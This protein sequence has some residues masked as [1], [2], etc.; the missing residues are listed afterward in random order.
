[1]TTGPSTDTIARKRRRKAQV[2]RWR[3]LQETMRDER[4]IHAR[5]RASACSKDLKAKRYDAL[6]A[7]FQEIEEGRG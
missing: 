6:M 5:I 7:R 3:M 4:E 2:R 1:M